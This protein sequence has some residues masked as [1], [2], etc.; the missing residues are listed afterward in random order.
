MEFLRWVT[1][2]GMETV[3]GRKDTGV[4]K[5]GKFDYRWFEI[6]L[7]ASSKCGYQ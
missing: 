1:R 7:M 6:S 4:G 5:T 3:E 2:Q